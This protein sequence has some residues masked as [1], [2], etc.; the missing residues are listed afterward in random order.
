[1]TAPCP[2]PRT[3]L[4]VEEVT[5]VRVAGFRTIRRRHA[6][7]REELAAATNLPPERIDEALGLLIARGGAVVGEHGQLLGIAGLTLEPSAHRLVLD[8]VDLHTWCAYD[9]VGIPAALGE[10]ATVGTVCGH[11]GEPIELAIQQGQ[12]PV[13]TR[14]VGWMPGGPCDN[15][16]ADFC[17]SANLFC[18]G[19]HLDAWR[20]RHDDPPGTPCS[21]SQLAAL[22]H[23]AWA[24]F[25]TPT[26]EP[27]Q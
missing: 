19:G 21:L 7:S 14:A 24:G 15:A 27:T 25:G 4:T 1:M 26:S 17:P 8:G 9:A 10:D 12:P 18:D 22:G 11:C 3:S 23:Q 5:A 20:N 16:L 6:A 13:S 2:A